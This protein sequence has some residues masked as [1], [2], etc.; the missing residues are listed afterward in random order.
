VPG[1]RAPHV[2]LAPG[3]SLY[4]ELAPAFT[5]LRTDPT[6][7]VQTMLLH[8]QKRGLPFKLIDLA[9][10]VLGPA[11]THALTLVRSDQHVV[12]RGAVPPTDPRPLLD[13]LR[14]AG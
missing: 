1:C 4:D 12:W 10:G 6:V 2:W 7:N 14:G 13:V 9:P 3:R 11:Y 8:A 5:L